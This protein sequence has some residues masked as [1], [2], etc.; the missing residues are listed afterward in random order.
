MLLLRSEERRVA[1]PKHIAPSFYEYDDVEMSFG[2]TLP[3]SNEQL[4][5]DAVH[6]NAA[7][8]AALPYAGLD[9]SQYAGLQGTHKTYGSQNAGDLEV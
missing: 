8:I 5:L 7:G 2:S 1:G 3:T 6:P 9:D 4:K